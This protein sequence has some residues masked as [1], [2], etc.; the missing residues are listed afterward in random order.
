MHRAPVLAAL[1]LALVL[2]ALAG[3]GSSPAPVPGSTLRATLV[4]RDGD[5]ALDPGPP[6]P[7][8]DRTDLGRPGWTVRTLATLGV[9]SDAHVRDEESPARAPFLDRFGTP[10]DSTFRPQERSPPR[11]STPPFAL[12]ARS[13]RTRCSSPATSPTTRSPTSSISR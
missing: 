12:C 10:Q 1:A 7:L 8:L 6:E 11:S 13:T 4:D 3:C 5:G 2:V 9:I